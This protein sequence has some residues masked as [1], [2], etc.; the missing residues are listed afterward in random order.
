M[1][2][3]STAADLSFPQSEAET[4]ITSK[5]FWYPQSRLMLKCL[6]S[7]DAKVS[8]MGG[9]AL[10]SPSS[11]DVTIEHRFE[12]ENCVGNPE[13]DEVE[14]D[15][16]TDGPVSSEAPERQ[17]I[18]QRAAPANG[19][20]PDRHLVLHQNVK[21]NI[22]NTIIQPALEFHIVSQSYIRKISSH[23]RYQRKRNT[24]D[25]EYQVITACRQYE[26][27]LKNHWR[28]RPRVL[29]MTHQELSE[30]VC[31]E[32]AQHS[33]RIFCVYIV[34]FWSH[35]LYSHRVAW[36]NLPVSDVAADALDVI[37]QTLMQ[38]TGQGRDSEADGD[39]AA[40]T[41]QCV[42]SLHPGSLWALLLF[43]S[44]CKVEHQQIWAVRQIRSIGER[45]A[46]RPRIPDHKFSSQR[47]AQNASRIATLIQELVKR[48]K[49]KDKRVHWQDLSADIF[50]CHFS[51]V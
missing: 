44:E 28:E 5:G 13:E 14:P 50:G 27:E 43:A 18:A 37:W 7:V 3:E 20:K 36:W 1:R 35:F 30:L 21:M 46:V 34:T 51:I 2:V 38:C 22:F 17:P 32:I 45:A 12:V 31:N 40:T 4:V 33:A 25:D 15:S 39:T 16:T 29:D 11:L 48:Q 19:K 26:I 42:T 24:A 49:Q 41:T 9:R 6:N 23:E 47:G 8:H 10:L